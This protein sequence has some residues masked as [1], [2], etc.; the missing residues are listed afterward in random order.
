MATHVYDSTIAGNPK[1]DK[2]SK[3]TALTFDSKSQEHDN[4][5]FAGVPIET[6]ENGVQKM[7]EEQH[8]VKIKMLEK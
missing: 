8:D 5:T 4:L 7:H 1:F 3:I 2:Y 6:L